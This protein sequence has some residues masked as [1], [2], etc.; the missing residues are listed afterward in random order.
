MLLDLFLCKGWGR[1]L[2]TNG[3]TRAKSLPQGGIAKAG[4]TVTI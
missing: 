2:V 1:G 4:A 3:A